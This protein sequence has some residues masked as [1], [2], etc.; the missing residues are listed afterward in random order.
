MGFPSP[1]ADYTARTLNID[2]ICQISANS[3]TVETTTG[4]AVV[5]RGKRPKPRDLVLIDLCGK[6]HFARVMGESLITDDGEAIEG[7]ALDDVTVA[8]VVT[9]IIN[10]AS[11]AD[12]D[13]IPVM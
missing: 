3:L 10:R 12:Q 9:F 1:A 6:S 4:F 5:E 13:D 7:D 2:V 8:G 11:G